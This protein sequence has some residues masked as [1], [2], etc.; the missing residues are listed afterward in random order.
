MRRLEQITAVVV[1]AG[2]AIVSYWLFFSWADGGGYRRNKRLS[3]PTA[4]QER[5][6]PDKDQGGLP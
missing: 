3:D 5:T 4:N 6:M 1:A 2:L